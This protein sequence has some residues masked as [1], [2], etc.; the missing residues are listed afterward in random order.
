ML[1]D[2]VILFKVKQDALPMSFRL[3]VKGLLDA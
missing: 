1:M 3:V 2:K